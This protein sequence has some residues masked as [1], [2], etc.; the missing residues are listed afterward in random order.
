M[1]TMTQ[2]SLSNM[3]RTKL[4]RCHCQRLLCKRVPVHLGKENSFILE[5]KHKQL[6]LRSYLIQITCPKCRTKYRISGEN[7]IEEK[8]VPVCR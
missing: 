5:I 7:G 3:S 2:A 6:E 1:R 8:V 4:V